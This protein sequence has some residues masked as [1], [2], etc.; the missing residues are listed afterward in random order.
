[1]EQ[2]E[3]IFHDAI[4]KI[5]PHN[6]DLFDVMKA[7]SSLKPQINS[8]MAKP[9]ISD[10]DDDNSLI[11]NENVIQ[12]NNQNDDNTETQD[13]SHPNSHTSNNTIVEVV[14]TTTTTEQVAT[15][16]VTNLEK[17]Q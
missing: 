6:Y 2:S 16:L 15:P 1:M 9:L 4:L 17:T 14:L 11:G 3:G 10:D 13:N 5:C 8:I 12:P 7:C